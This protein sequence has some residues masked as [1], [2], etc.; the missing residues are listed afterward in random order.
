MLLPVIKSLV[1]NV[2][3]FLNVFSF[4]LSMGMKKFS[5]HSLIP[6]SKGTHHV[7]VK[8]QERKTALLKFAADVLNTTPDNLKIVRREYLDDLAESGT[9]DEIFFIN[10]LANERLLVLKVKEE[11]STHRGPSNELAAMRYMEHLPFKDF[12]PVKL[13]GSTNLIFDSQ[14][15][16]VIAMERAPGKTLNTYLSEISSLPEACAKRKQLLEE[17]SEGVRATAKALAELHSIQP[18]TEINPIYKQRKNYVFN[19][20]LNKTPGSK[21]QE[22]LEHFNTLKDNSPRG[23]IHGDL[24]P[25]NIFYDAKSKKVTF[26]DFE[27]LLDSTSGGPVAFDLAQFSLLFEAL[28]NF[29]GFTEEEQ[30]ILDRTF[31]LEYSMHGPVVPSESKAFYRALLEMSYITGFDIEV[32]P[33]EVDAQTLQAEALSNYFAKD[34]YLKIHS[35]SLSKPN[36]ALPA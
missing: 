35:V 4:P 28:G 13:Y 19:K 30:K 6:G 20:F 33:F 29:Y 14:L 12:R 22:A 26:I 8:N 10:N 5:L 34:L 27:T 36:E 9:I 32:D 2:F 18:K 31:F 24:N 7:E 3:V 11:R 15:Y 23:L 21:T 25:G 16:E 1:L 17:L